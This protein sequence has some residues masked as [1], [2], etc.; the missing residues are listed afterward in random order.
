MT[1][2]IGKC[3]AQSIGILIQVRCQND[4]GDRWFFQRPLERLFGSSFLKAA[5]IGITSAQSLA[6][7]PAAT[8]KAELRNTEAKPKRNLGNGRWRFLRKRGQE[9]LSIDFN[10]LLTFTHRCRAQIREPLSSPGR[11]AIAQFVKH[12]VN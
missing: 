7:L 9:L 3:D 6:K 1:T 12:R 11:R 5:P 10:S 4:E 2:E 8:A